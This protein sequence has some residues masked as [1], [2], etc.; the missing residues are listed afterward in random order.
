MSQQKL[1]SVA[2]FKNK[3]ALIGI[4][5]LGYVG[6]PLML[7]YNAIGYQVLGIDIDEDKV[8]K[9]NAGESY[10]EHIPADKIATARQRGFEATTDFQRVSECDA[11][12]LCV[13]TPLNK[14]RE[15]DMSFVI[16]TTDALKPYLRAGQV[17]SLE[18]TTY[19]GTTEEELLPRVQER[20]LVVGESIFLVYSPER[21]DPGNPNFETR[22]IPKVIGGHT[23]ACLEVGVALYE[24]AIDQVVSVSSTKAAEMTKL[25]ENIHRAVN[26]GLV[27]EMKVVADRM[28]ID[29]FEVVDAAATKP[30]GF[31][32]YYPGPGLGGHCIPID[33]F[34]LT[35]KAREYGLHTRFIELSGE[36]NQAMP[37][38]VL[39][40]L[41]D[42]LNESGKALKGSKV[43]VLGIAY[44][45]NVDDMRESPSVE[46]MEL[47]EAKGGVVAYSDPHV[48]VFPKMREHNFK[49]KSEALTAENL[50]NFDAVVLATDH[51]KFDYELIKQHAKLIVDSRGKYR[52]PAP[53]II[54]A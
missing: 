36:V 43:L 47:I 44:K 9:L 18:S 16:N 27:N 31:T 37:E 33:P 5:G 50:A 1:A 29:I 45:K 25:L 35:W 41:M 51:D 2:K 7:R 34:Y 26:I 53:H 20:G 49:L 15:P 32:A 13:P 23:P 3:E 39:S 42:G 21:E 22:T 48:P 8:G 11:L 4:V 38:Y 12:I 54:K 52:A 40:K 28:G 10:I 30:F 17:V 6:L 46:I 24:Q 14:Y 19:P